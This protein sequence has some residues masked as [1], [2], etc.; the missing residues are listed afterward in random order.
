M[1]ERVVI[2]DDEPAIRA[3]LSAHLSSLPLD[4]RTA[5]DAAEALLLAAGEPRPSLVLS[6]IEMPGLSGI[7]LLGAPEGA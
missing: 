5:K 4:C 6:D 3:L 1:K 2:V 7:E